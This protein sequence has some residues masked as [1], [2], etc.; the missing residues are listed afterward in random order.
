MSD[1]LD[2]KAVLALA[3]PLV[4]AGLAVHRLHKRSKRPVGDLWSSAAV[5]TFHELSERY[6]EGENLGVRLGD[7]S[8]TDS[9]YLHLID[10]DIRDPGQESAAWAKLEGHRCL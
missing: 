8:K 3:E 5:L 10:L 1:A 9:G 4:S 2:A 6:Q 7:W